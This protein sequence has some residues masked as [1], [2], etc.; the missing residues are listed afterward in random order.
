[1]AAISIR[2]VLEQFLSCIG[3]VT[4]AVSA[5][6]ARYST[7]PAKWRYTTTEYPIAR[8]IPGRNHHNPTISPCSAVAGLWIVRLKSGAVFAGS[9]FGNTQK[10]T[11]VNIPT[12]YRPD[13]RNACRSCR[14]ELSTIPIMPTTASAGNRRPQGWLRNCFMRPGWIEKLAANISNV[15]ATEAA[16]HFAPKERVRSCR[17]PAVFNTTHRLPCT[18]TCRT[19]VDNVH[20]SS[21]MFG[22]CRKSFGSLTS[23]CAA[24]ILIPP[25]K[26]GL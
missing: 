14:R 7:L 12:R 18:A 11:L 9:T 24:P 5:G 2:S 23:A 17:L 1:M 6:N 19:P 22:L 16:R 13:A 25:R 21:G 3:H 20:L 15:I 4:E 10:A 8:A 26:K